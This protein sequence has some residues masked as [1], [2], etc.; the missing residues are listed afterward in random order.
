[1]DAQ[2][3]IE[4]SGLKAEDSKGIAS[5]VKSKHLPG[6]L[7]LVVVNTVDRSRKLFEEL[8]KLYKGGQTKGRGKKS[9]DPAS[10]APDLKLIHSRFR[11]MEREQWMEWLKA[12]SPREGRIVISTQGRG[13][14]GGYVRPD[15][16][17]RTRP[18][19]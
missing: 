13:G 9:S 18:L 3:L 12:E 7:T 16:H 19:A 15:A 8:Q 10:L 2:K 11:P 4:P 6:S 5:L 14:R 17:H 1:M